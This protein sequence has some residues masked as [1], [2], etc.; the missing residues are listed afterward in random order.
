MSALRV[1][2]NL[3]HFGIT[4]LRYFEIY[5]YIHVTYVYTFQ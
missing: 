4:A 2:V 5:I 3:I 1:S